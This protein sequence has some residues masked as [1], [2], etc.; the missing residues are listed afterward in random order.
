MTDADRR[1]EKNYIPEPNSGCWLWLGF[2]TG[3]RGYGYLQVN[4]KSIRAHRFS[5]EKYKGA[6]GD[7]VIDHLCNV[8]SCVNPDH[9]EAVTQK[10]NTRRAHA[11][12]VKV[13][14]CPKGHPKFG[15]NIYINPKNGNAACRECV[16]LSVRKYQERKRYERRSA[17]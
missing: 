14:F 9:L 3:S 5:Y 7:A 13:K 12:R 1:F 6:I 8:P 15:S 4:G 10:I 17:T 2:L 16:R 11:N